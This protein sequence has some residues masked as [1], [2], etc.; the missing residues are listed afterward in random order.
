MTGY[1]NQ[2]HQLL[3]A[4]GSCHSTR[5]IRANSRAKSSWSRNNT[6]TKWSQNDSRFD[7]GSIDELAVDTIIG[8]HSIEDSCWFRTV[9]YKLVMKRSQDDWWRS[10]VKI[11]AELLSAM[12]RIYKLLVLVLGLDSPCILTALY[13]LELLMHDAFKCSRDI[14]TLYTLDTHLLTS[15]PF[16][17]RDSRNITL[18]RLHSFPHHRSQFFDVRNPRNINL[19]RLRLACWGASLPFPKPKTAELQV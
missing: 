6:K 18:H 8:R 4:Q 12:W 10:E 14:Y 17:V 15:Q 9:G 5:C 3:F 19:H 13:T 1:Q 11:M 2:G 7:N 16:D